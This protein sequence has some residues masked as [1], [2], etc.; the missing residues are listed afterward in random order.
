MYK[1]FT[2][3]KCL[4]ISF[5]IS[6]LIIPSASY[7]VHASSS[8][9]DYI[10]PFECGSTL[11]FSSKG[12]DAND[13]LSSSTPKQNPAPFLESGGYCVLLKSGETFNFSSSIRVGSNT[14]L[15]VYGGKKRAK[16]N[17][18]QESSSVFEQDVNDSSIYTI[19]LNES[20]IDAGW[21]SI[22]GYNNWQKVASVGNLANNNDYC[23][24]DTNGLLYIRSSSVLTGKKLKYALDANAI[25]VAS[26]ANN[27]VINKIE[28]TGAGK[29][30]IS[31]SSG[32]NILVNRCYVHDIG[33]SYLNKQKKNK[34]GNG[35][36]IWATDSHN[37]FITNNYIEN[38]Y[39]TGITAQITADAFKNDSDN[40]L[41]EG[42][43]VNN[44]NYCFEF[45]QYGKAHAIRNMT[46]RNNILEG[47]KDI[48]NGYR[49]S[50]SYTSLICL[51]GCDNNESSI[52]I[53][54]NYCYNTN[55][56]GIAFGGK[57]LSW[58]RVYD[59]YIA[60]TPEKIKNGN[61]EIFV[62]NI[63]DDSAVSNY[64]TIINSTISS[65]K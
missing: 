57:P 13:G 12:N 44:C 54:G 11:Y 9:Y 51:W 19:K 43:Y 30:G 15:S 58:C 45:F 48:T 47:A 55:Y 22:D 33:N 21:I 40:L 31:I 26:G 14:Q 42:N 23:I 18:L 34:Y 59:N 6:I 62:S 20:A 29:H 61:E 8:S 10:Q 38:C 32:N 36:Q 24:G 60:C 5:L 41:F 64:K 46:V 52:D 28:I 1:L 35:I 4:I 3:L 63:I 17:F 49:A 16:L 65:L 56:Y 53:Y 37:I 27:V 7:T 2:A 50:T 25:Q 39:D